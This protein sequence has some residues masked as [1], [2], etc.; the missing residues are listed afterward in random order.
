MKCFDIPSISWL[1]SYAFPSYLI[2][3]LGFSI[4]LRPAKSKGLVIPRPTAVGSGE[5]GWE[6]FQ[7]VDEPQGTGS[8]LCLS[9][10]YIPSNSS[11]RDKPYKVWILF[12]LMRLNSL[13]LSSNGKKSIALHVSHDLISAFSPGL[14]WNWSPSVL[15][16]LTCDLPHPP[17]PFWNWGSVTFLISSILE[18]IL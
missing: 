11:S 12:Y 6:S 16:F 1:F 8:I 10:P 4:C 15:G 17:F 7:R 9:N 13:K 3:A 18:L 2:K 14:W 5:A